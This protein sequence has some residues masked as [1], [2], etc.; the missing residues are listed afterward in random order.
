M[1]L[2]MLMVLRFLVD[3]MVYERKVGEQEEREEREGRE[4]REGFKL[5]REDYRQGRAGREGGSQDNCCYQV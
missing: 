2:V 3:A 4:G 5:R 1:I